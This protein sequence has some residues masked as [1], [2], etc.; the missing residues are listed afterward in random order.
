MKLTALILMLST[1]TYALAPELLAPAFAAFGAA[2][3]AGKPAFAAPNDTAPTGALSEEES[4]CFAARA[5]ADPDLASFEG[6]SA[7]GVLVTVLV[8]VLLVVL[9][10]YI[11]D[12]GHY[13]KSEP[14]TGAP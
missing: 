6:G 10:I 7:A 14:M 4:A 11:L 1:F 3:A 12:L 9:I 8:I 13:H 5:A 2:A